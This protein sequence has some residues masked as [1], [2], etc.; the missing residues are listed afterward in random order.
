MNMNIFPVNEI[1]KLGRSENPRAMKLMKIYL[2]NPNRH[3]MNVAESDLYYLEAPSLDRVSARTLEPYEKLSL[4][5]E[6]FLLVKSKPRTRTAILN[7]RWQSR[8]KFGT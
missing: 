6:N 4:L 2:S 5:K 8:M 1:G 3:K 7:W